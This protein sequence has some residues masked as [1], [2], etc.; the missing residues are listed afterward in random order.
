MVSDEYLS[1]M[2]KGKG[3][4]LSVAESCTGGM[5]SSKITAIP[6][7]SEFFLGSVVSYSYASKTSL[8]K[9]RRETIAEHGAVSAETA[10]EMAAGVAD[11]FRSDVS[12]AVTGI[13]GPSGGSEEKPVGLV[14]ISVR[15]K[16]RVRTTRNMFEGS[17]AEIRAAASDAVISE[18]IK[19][20]DG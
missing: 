17:R 16:N 9:V 3:L 10:E 6:G 13:A 4:T 11:L 1:S 14:F 7:A 5:I 18:I 12:A 2:M 8:F 15:Y 20:V 19:A